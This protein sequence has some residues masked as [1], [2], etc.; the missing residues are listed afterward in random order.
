M[1]AALAVHESVKA[2]SLR[3]L[4]VKGPVLKLLSAPSLSAS[5]LVQNV[6]LDDEAKKR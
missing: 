4:P 3:L 6:V 1:A 5:I 2:L